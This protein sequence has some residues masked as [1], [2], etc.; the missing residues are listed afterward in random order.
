MN[1]IAFWMELCI[2]LS[3]K[4]KC[5]CYHCQHYILFYKAELRIEAKHGNTCYSNWEADAGGLSEVQG[6]SG[7][8]RHY[9][10]QE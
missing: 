6:Q 1:D 9:H 8:Q 10:V 5:L 4:N 7:L 2:F 3:A